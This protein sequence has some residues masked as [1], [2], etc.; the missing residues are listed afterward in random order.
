MKHYGVSLEVF[1]DDVVIH[2]ASYSLLARSGEGAIKKAHKEML[3]TYKP[4][5]GCR[6]KATAKKN[7]G[8]DVPVQGC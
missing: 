2:T 8:S 1:L 7:P 6:I 5:T 4:P 3:K